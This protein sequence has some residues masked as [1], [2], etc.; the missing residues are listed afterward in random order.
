MK[1]YDQSIEIT[2]VM[3]KIFGG[4]FFRPSLAISG[5]AGIATELSKL[6]TNKNEMLKWQDKLVTYFSATEN[7][8]ENCCALKVDYFSQIIVFAESADGMPF[9]FDY[10]SSETAP[11]IIWWDD[12]CWVRICDSQDAFIALFINS[13]IPSQSQLPIS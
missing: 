4:H 1:L 9:C 7:N 12:N 11:T 3:A 2:T 13:K 6:I 8:D 5:K 10:R